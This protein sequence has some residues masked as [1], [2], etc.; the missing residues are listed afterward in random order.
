LVIVGARRGQEGADQGVDRGTVKWFS[1]EKGYGFVSLKP[2]DVIACSLS[3][4][5]GTLLTIVPTGYAQ[6]ELRRI[7][8][9][10]TWVNRVIPNR[11]LLV[12]VSKSLSRGLRRPE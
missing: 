1:E 2:E 10:S 9:P 7:H 3:A 6:R 5:R 12:R 11:Q 4:W 8:L